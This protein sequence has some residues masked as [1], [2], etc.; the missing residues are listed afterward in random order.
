MEKQAAQDLLANA[1]GSLFAE[2]E[3][4]AGI[5][6]AAGISREE[7]N[8]IIEDGLE[9]P[10]C[11]KKYR[12]TNR[13]RKFYEE[14]LL[15]AELNEQ[16]VQDAGVTSGKTED[17]PQTLEI[18]QRQ[19]KYIP[20]MIADGI[21]S[22]DGKTP[23]KSLDKVACFLKEKGQNVSVRLLM[24]LGLQ[25]RNGKSYAERTY[26]HAVNMAYTI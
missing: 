9:L 2:A 11:I 16:V 14:K 21:L 25:K 1:M 17:A 4:E 15:K 12:E 19:N 22:K 6:E 23:L 26:E 18:S 20:Q 5:A 13:K 10:E 3:I 7:Y 8:K 24:D